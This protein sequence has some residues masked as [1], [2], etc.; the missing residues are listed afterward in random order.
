MPEISL[1][2][3]CNRLK[4]VPQANEEAVIE[5]ITAMENRVREQ[6]SALT[7][8]NGKITALE[9]DKTTLTNAV[10][11]LKTEKETAEK[12]AKKVNAEALIAAAVKLGTIKN[13]VEVKEKW[14]AKA[15]ADYDGTKELIE[16]I[17]VNAVSNRIKVGE[18]SKGAANLN[19]LDNAVAIEM[20]RIQ[21][22]LNGRP[23]VK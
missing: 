4:L 23:E 22:K 21:N 9:T 6:E 16:S 17:P 1:T 11:T 19:D 7:A 14:V 12:S 13:E 5:A 20:A 18:Q 2:R 3:I 15:I 8:A 10:N